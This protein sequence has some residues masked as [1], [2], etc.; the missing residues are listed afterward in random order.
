MPCDEPSRLETT[1][2]VTVGPHAFLSLDM[3]PH[4]HRGNRDAG[5]AGA[6]LRWSSVVIFAFCAYRLAPLTHR[7]A[8]TANSPSTRPETMPITGPVMTIISLGDAGIDSI[9]AA[10]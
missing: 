8:T 9:I 5:L 1:W 6:P 4:R 2:S 10:S 7:L 3:C